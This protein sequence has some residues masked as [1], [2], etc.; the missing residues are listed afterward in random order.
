MDPDRAGAELPAVPDEVVGLA[1]AAP[2]S[3]SISSSSPGRTPVNG[4]CAERPALAVLVP[5]EEREV[6]HPEE[7][8]AASR[9]SARARRPRCVR[10]PPR[11][12]A[13][14]AGCVGAEEHRRARRRRPNRLELVLGEELRDRRAHLALLVERPG[15]RGPSPPHS[16]ASS[17]SRSSSARESSCGTR[18]VAHARRLAKTPNSEPRVTSVASCDLEAEAQVG[19]VG[20][21]A[22]PSPR[23]RSA[24]ERALRRLRAQA[25][26]RTA[27]T[28][29]SSS[30]RLLAVGEGHLD[31]ELPELELAGRRADPRPGSRS[32]SGSSA[33]ARRS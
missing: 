23:A 3:D 20:A 30:R 13:T 1:D 18:Q 4:W 10:R 15:R 7:L 14:V 21:V 33:R 8:V 28:R 12:R 17:S 6:G 22:R 16:F 29:S 26:R 2:G 19:L 32:R 31:V 11:T 27:T 25:P 24:A 9:R 5:L